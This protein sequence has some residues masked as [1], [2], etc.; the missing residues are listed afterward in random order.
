MEAKHPLDEAALELF[1]ALVEALKEACEEIRELRRYA[2]NHGRMYDSEEYEEGLAVL[3]QAL[4][5]E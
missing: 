3:S 2:N 4:G 5:G 1:P